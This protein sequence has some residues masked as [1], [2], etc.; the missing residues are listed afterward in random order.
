MGFNGSWNSTTDHVEGAKEDR[1]PDQAFNE[2]ESEGSETYS[3]H[4]FLLP[5]FRFRCMLFH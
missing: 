3:L 4:P 5:E 1:K 2:E